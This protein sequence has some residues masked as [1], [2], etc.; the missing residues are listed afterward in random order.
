M[1]LYRINQLTDLTWPSRLGGKRVTSGPEQICAD[2]VSLRRSNSIDKRLELR[3]RLRIYG[4]RV[5]QVQF[6]WAARI[7]FAAAQVLQSYLLLHF[8]YLRQIFWTFDGFGELYPR[9]FLL[10]YLI[11][12]EV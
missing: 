9:Y 5:Y 2:S 8:F 10:R 1:L 11:V 12:Q 4:G 7:L 6:L 3:S